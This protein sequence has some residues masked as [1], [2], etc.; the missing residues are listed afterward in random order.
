MLRLYKLVLLYLL[1]CQDQNVLGRKI[2]NGGKA[3]EMLMTYVASVQS[4]DKHVC[5]GFAVSNE[6]V[7]THGKCTFDKDKAMV[8]LGTHF[9]DRPLHKITKH[10]ESTCNPPPEI[11]NEI[12]LLQIDQYK[13]DI[14]IPTI[15]LSDTAVNPGDSCRVAGWAMTS[16]KSI[17]LIFLTM[18]PVHLEAKKHFVRLIWA[19]PSCA[20]GKL[21]KLRNGPTYVP[22]QYYPASSSVS[23]N[24]FLG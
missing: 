4:N 24:T 3:G 8:A 22:T 18:L 12:K 2:K 5:G 10:I 17:G 9:L 11:G 19:S 21:S 6:F 15:H 20:M 7:V 23:Q 13:K 1:A 14:K 16:A